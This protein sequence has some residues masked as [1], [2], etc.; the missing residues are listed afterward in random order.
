LKLVGAS[1]Y[2]FRSMIGVTREASPEGFDSE[3]VSQLIES[4]V[5]KGAIGKTLGKKGG[6][7]WYVTEAGRKQLMSY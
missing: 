7:R 3:E 4:L 1:K 5:K 6:E 2:S